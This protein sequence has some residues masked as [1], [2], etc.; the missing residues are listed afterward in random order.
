MPNL[1]TGLVAYPENMPTPTEVLYVAGLNTGKPYEASAR[2]F[3]PNFYDCSGYVTVVLRALGIEPGPSPWTS[4]SIAAWCYD[5]GMEVSVDEA[6]RTPGALLFMGPNRGLEGWG[7][8]GHIAISRGNGTVFETPAW[9]AWGHGSG[10]GSAYGR[11]WTGGALVPGVHAGDVA[12][13][14]VPQ[15]PALQRGSMGP[16]VGDWQVFLNAAG[17]A[18]PLAIDGEYGPGTENA[19]RWFQT[20]CKIVSDG[21]VGPDTWA[22]RR[23]IES[24]P[25]SSPAPEPTPVPQA[26]VLDYS[27]ARPDPAEM[28]EVAEGVIRYLSP[29]PSKNLSLDEYAALKAAGLR[30]AVVWESSARRALDGHDAGVEDAEEAVRQAAALGYTDIIYFANDTNTK[31]GEA[32]ASVISYFVGVGEVMGGRPIGYYGGDAPGSILL[33]NGNVDAFWQAGATSWSYVWPHPSAAL[34]QQVGDPYG[35]GVDVNVV[36]SD[37]WDLGWVAPPPDPEPETPT[38]P[39]PS[40]DQ[41]LAHAAEHSTWRAARA[42]IK[43]DLARRA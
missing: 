15:D 22:A 39:P 25:P 36:Q 34:V 17:Y 3:G 32:M 1:G 29:D 28:A 21:K 41:V 31:D 30:V 2:R 12:Y 13:L 16:A 5:A 43:A 24:L 38:I 42:S 19:V 40:L 6:I 37:H 10:I 35:W 26:L 4:W 11:N 7:S 18:P 8:T 23:F 20:L 33:W 27:W 9:G 14:P